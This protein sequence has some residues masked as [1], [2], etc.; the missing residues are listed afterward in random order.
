M[1][2]KPWMPLWIADYRAD[3]GHLSAAEHGAYLLLIMHYWQTGGLPD[4]DRQL[5]RIACMAPVE[6]KRA[7]PVLVEFFDAG[8]KHGRIEKELQH[9]EHVSSKRSEAAIQMHERRR[10]N[11]DAN[12]PQMQRQPQSQPQPHSFSNGVEGGKAKG[13]SPP[14]HCAT[15]KIAGRA[16]R[17]YVK[18]GT[19]EWDA[20]A[21]AFA[22]KHGCSPVPNEHGGK[23]FDWM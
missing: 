7:R 8:W 23:W 15:Q 21:Q 12:A 17:I 9:A 18:E 14:K 2:A 20:Y 10:A 11:A 19:P 6:W 16:A 4:D 3:T 1:T 5:A 13:W 22:E